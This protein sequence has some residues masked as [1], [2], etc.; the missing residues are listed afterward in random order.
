MSAIADAAGADAGA[1]DRLVASARAS[2]L[3]ELRDDCAR[4]KAAASADAESRRARI[5]HRRSLRTYTDAEG[6]WHLHARNN[7]EVG[8]E[9]MAVL[10][11]IRDRLFAQA[12][13]AARR[14]PTEDYATDALH[15]LARDAAGTGSTATATA[16]TTPTRPTPTRPKAA[17]ASRAKDHR[18]GRPG[19]AATGLSRPR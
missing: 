2:S 10:D 15:A 9:I 13:T 7:P 12:R 16:D 4:T 11:A 1:E 6:A 3:Q 5:H 19:G 8:A 18:A 17:G 14:E